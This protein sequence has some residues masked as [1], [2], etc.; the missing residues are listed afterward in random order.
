MPSAMSRPWKHPKAGIYQLRKAVP[1]DLRKIVGKR[2]EKV[3]LQTRDPGEAKQ[4]FAKAL[5]EVETRWANLRTGPKLRTEREAHELAVVAY[6][7]WLQM[8]RDNPSQLT[9]WDVVA[10]DR[11]F[12]PPRDQGAD[13]CCVSASVG[14]R[15]GVA[16]GQDFPDGTGVFGCR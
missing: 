6:D 9:G 2:E 3:S 11:L 15:A 1:E 16:R 10:G 12:G 13:P 8:Y 14:W 7:Q 5:A 4:C